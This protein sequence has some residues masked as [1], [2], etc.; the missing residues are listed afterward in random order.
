MFR[1]TTTHPPLGVAL[2]TIDRRAAAVYGR[3]YIHLTVPYTARG[4]RLQA[5]QYA[6]LNVDNDPTRYVMRIYFRLTEIS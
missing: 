4:G 3:E 1:D 5:E 6:R 2:H